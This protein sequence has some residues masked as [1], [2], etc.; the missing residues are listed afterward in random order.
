MN[1]S[2]NAVQAS[3][4]AN[5][6]S[7]EALQQAGAEQDIAEAT[8]EQPLFG[9]VVSLTALWRLVKEQLALVADATSGTAKESN[10]AKRSLINLQ[11]DTQIEDL[12]NRENNLR[13]QKKA[14]EANKILNAF[15][16]A[17]SLLAAIITMP[18]NP[19]VGCIMLGTLVASIVVPIVVDKIL[20]AA[21]VDK[22]TRDKV[23]MGL[24]I[25]ISLLGAIISLNPVQMIKS[26]GSAV[27][28]GVRVGAQTVINGLKSLPTVLSNINWGSMGKSIGEVAANAATKL[29]DM[30]QDLAKT[31]KTFF[32][33]LASGSKSTATVGSTLANKWQDL[34]VIV[35]ATMYT[36]TNALKTAGSTA[37]TTLKGAFEALKNADEILNGVMAAIR[38]AGQNFVE[39]MRNL[40]VYL[41]AFGHA[42]RTAPGETLKATINDFLDW[43]GKM[44]TSFD[45]AQAVRVNQVT[46][47]ATAATTTVQTGYAIASAAIAKDTEINSARLDEVLTI[48]Q[49]VLEQLNS[50]MRLFQQALQSLMTLN[51]DYR[52]F[53][54][55]QIAANHL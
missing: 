27:A 40:G 52:D 19:V 3:A 11:R 18:F 9:A 51:S 7:E 15:V 29:A 30:V 1:I 26:L 22:A 44:A 14:Q 46:S 48:I 43:V 49:T 42:M 45:K 8:P 31:V 13:E 50:A 10:D 37:A 36:V 54:Q 12:K 34:K 21:G 17:F 38:T 35:Q 33:S 53:I 5:Y 47:V 16:F 41:R 6:V 2:L 32:A 20:E 39:M 23:R 4:N 24:E 28:A 55:R 25:G